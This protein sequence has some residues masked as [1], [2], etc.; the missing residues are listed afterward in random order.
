M[1]TMK[2]GN[3]YKIKIMLTIFIQYRPT[4]NTSFVNILFG[5]EF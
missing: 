3:N 5:S 4:V 1:A 2:M